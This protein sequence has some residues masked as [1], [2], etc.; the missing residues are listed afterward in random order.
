MHNELAATVLDM[1]AFD[2]ERLMD[3]ENAVLCSVEEDVRKSSDDLVA[4]A[5]GLGVR[6]DV[7][8]VVDARLRDDWLRRRC[9]FGVFRADMFLFFLVEII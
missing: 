1:L 4:D 7:S 9:V 8:F 3:D 6:I 2:E 5:V